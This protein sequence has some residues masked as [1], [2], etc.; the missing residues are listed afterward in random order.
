MKFQIPQ[1]ER[2]NVIETIF[3]NFQDFVLI[4]KNFQNFE[5]ILKFFKNIVFVLFQV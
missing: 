1:T 5:K 4:S 2:N 3:E